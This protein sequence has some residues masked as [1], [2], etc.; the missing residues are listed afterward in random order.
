MNIH[1]RPFA[2]I[3]SLWYLLPS[4]L[5]AFI[6]KY[7]L[8]LHLAKAPLKL[9][10]PRPSLLVFTLLFALAGSGLGIRICRCY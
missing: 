5:F 4:Q 7:T 8:L 2:T 3:L 1:Q 10:L 6:P 9:P